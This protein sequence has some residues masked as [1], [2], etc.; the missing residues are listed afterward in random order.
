MKK[1]PAP[2]YWLWI[3]IGGVGGG[4]LVA[5]VLVQIG[6]LLESLAP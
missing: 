5:H 1:I 4:V 3:T 6:Y 2:P